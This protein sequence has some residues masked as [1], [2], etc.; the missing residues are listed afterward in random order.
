MRL[1]T[2][3]LPPGA[4]ALAFADLRPPDSAFA[5]AAEEACREQSAAVA[6]HSHR[7]W[8]YG[9]ALAALDGAGADAELLY[10]ACLVHDHGIERAV[11]GEDFT[12][13]SAARAEACAQQ[14]GAGPE[15][16]AAVADAITVH[17]TPGIDVATDGALGVYVQAGAM[18]DLAGL[19]AGDVPAAYRADVAAANP[20]AGVT[21]AIVPLI[22]AEARANPAGRF[23]LLHRCGL[24]VLIRASPMRPR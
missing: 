9:S 8:A 12:L 13:R 24:T 18:L 5:R 4:H 11:P 14:A 17:T 16:A 2:G 23:G 3:R 1:A 22:A 7:A 21:R 15:A 6:G 10:V 20:R 19:R